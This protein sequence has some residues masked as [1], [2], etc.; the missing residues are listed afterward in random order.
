[1]R[2]SRIPLERLRAFKSLAAKYVGVPED[3]PEEAIL[4]A[5]KTA[6]DQRQDP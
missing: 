5:I 1:M 4:Q 3:S 6:L 2:S